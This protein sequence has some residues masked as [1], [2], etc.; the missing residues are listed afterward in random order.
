MP[1][2]LWPSSFEHSSC[3]HRIASIL[4]SRFL[5]HLQAANQRA[6]RGG[7]SGSISL[8]AQGQDSLVF[9]RVI[10][11]FSAHIEPGDI[12]DGIDNFNELDGDA[13]TEDSITEHT[14]V[15]PLTKSTNEIIPQ[16]DLNPKNDNRVMVEEA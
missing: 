2:L 4:I 9:E 13:I 14:G 8:P 6:V 5:L 15:T 12:I 11:P 10:G 3:I 1:T 7:F 16:A